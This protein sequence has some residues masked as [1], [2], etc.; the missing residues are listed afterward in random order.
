MT[1]LDARSEPIP[2]PTPQAH[3]TTPRLYNDKTFSDITICFGVDTIC[4]HK[5]VLS[6]SSDYFLNAFSGPF[7]VSDLCLPSKQYRPPNMY[8]QESTAKEMHIFEDDLAAVI[9]MIRFIYGFGISDNDCT[10]FRQIETMTIADKYGVESLYAAT[11]ADIAEHL[12]HLALPWADFYPDLLHDI[13]AAP[14]CDAEIRR[15]AVGVAKRDLNG[16]M[17]QEDFKKVILENP[18]IAMGVLN[19]VASGDGKNGANVEAAQTD[20]AN[21][22]RTFYSP[23]AVADLRQRLGFPPRVAYGQSAHMQAPPPP[24]AT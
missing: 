23:R 24:P 11:K 16:W 22:T 18:E 20:A 7:K 2:F 6:M 3:L 17:Q 5:A 10:T 9:D 1:W 8:V 14:A 13:Y 15:L 4:A 21:S 12:E 19:S